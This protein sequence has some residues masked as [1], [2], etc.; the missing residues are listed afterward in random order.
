MDPDKDLT[1]EWKSEHAECLSAL[2]AQENA[3]AM[4][5]QPFV[6][7]AQ[8]KSDKIRVALDLTEEWDKLGSDSALLT[9]VVVARKEFVEQY[10]AAVTDF[11]AHYEASVTYV[12][13]HVEEA[14]A[15]IENMTLFRRSRSQG[16]A[17]VQYC[18]DH[19]RGDE[20]KAL[21]ISQSAV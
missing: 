14:A 16:S 17:K 18:I 12:N 15:L 10:P 1:I 20:A 11:L 7:T 9:G 19:R 4:L 13:E 21:W 2:M 8:A 5:P 3:V 6:T